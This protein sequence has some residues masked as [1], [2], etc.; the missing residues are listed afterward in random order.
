M[1]I[2]THVSAECMSSTKCS[3]VMEFAEANGLEVVGCGIDCGMMALVVYGN[4]NTASKIVPFV[5]DINGGNY[6]KAE[7]I[8]EEEFEELCQ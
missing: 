2:F 8:S 4:A 1:T 6:C 5:H 3:S 7:L